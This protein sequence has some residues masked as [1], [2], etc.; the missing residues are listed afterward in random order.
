M[1][2]VVVEQPVEV[3]A[4]LE[5]TVSEPAAPEVMAEEP[6]VEPEPVSEEQ[7]EELNKGL[8]PAELEVVMVQDQP[9]RVVEKQ[10]V[11]INGKPYVQVK[12]VEGVTY[13]L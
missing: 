11:V 1:E 5:L 13:L 9:V 6:M 4:P 3:V 8:A 10:D 12:S 2:E 7:L